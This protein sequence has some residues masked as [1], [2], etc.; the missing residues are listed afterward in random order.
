M[1]R[2]EKSDEA[3]VPEKQANKA[4]E[5]AAELVEGRAS[6]KRNAEQRSAVRTQ[7]RVTASQG[8]GSVRKAAR[9]HR[10]ARFTNLLHH[11]DVTLLRESFH[12]LKRAAAAGSDGVRWK[13]YQEGLEERLVDLHTRIHTG[14]YRAQPARRTTIPKADGSSRSL[15]IWCL[16]DKIV[17]QSVTTVLS[18]VFEEDFL[19]F[20][21]GFR[22]GRGQHDALDALTVGICRR[23][24]NWILDADVQSFFDRIDHDWM[25]RFMEHRIGDKRLL[26]LVRKWL[27]VGVLDEE[28][29]R[30]PSSRGAAQGAVIS[31]LLANIYLHYVLDLWSNSWRKRRAT[32]DII[33]VRYADDV[34]LGFQS[35]ADANRFR[36]DLDNRLAKFALQLHP[37]KTKLIRFGRFA[38]QDSRQFDGAKASTFDFLGFTHYCTV[39]RTSG[40]F[41]VGRKTIKKRMI[42]TLKDI[43]LSL[44]QRLH[45]PIAETGQ[46]LQRVLS[47]HQNYF[48]VPC[49]YGS[50]QFFFRR[51]GWYWFRSLRR[52]SQRHRMTVA[53]FHRIMARYFPAVRVFHPYPAVR[54]DAK[55]QGRSPVR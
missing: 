47:G 16:E 22:Q 7:S 39:T 29:N 49:N 50:V 52:R 2:D 43:K 32:G 10:S 46:W 21:Y 45:R 33:I 30:V 44:R 37:K 8:L 23:K 54:F 6:A 28:G 53:R 18:A 31:P 38:M 13:D 24:V 40:R 26:R 27:K 20:S 15:S 4:A 25:M 14:R 42:S 17:Q 3:V 5:A 55:T 41:M 35:K 34:V 11:V 1:S 51:V 19:G 12:S 9:K 48:G 36:E